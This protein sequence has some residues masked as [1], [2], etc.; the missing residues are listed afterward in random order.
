MD[1]VAHKRPIEEIR[2]G[3]FGGT[4][5]RDIYFNVNGK[6]YKQSW[7]ELDQ[8]KNID[9]KYYCSDYDDVSVNKHGVKC[10]ASLKFWEN[11]GCNNKMVLVV[12]QILVGQ[13]IFR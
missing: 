6:C 10:G 5:S 2:E 4:Y 11:K 9:Q 12:F 7:K 13:K 1:F 8:L 3:A